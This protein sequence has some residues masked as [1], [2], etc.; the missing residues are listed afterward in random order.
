MIAWKI[1]MA[2]HGPGYQLMTDQLEAFGL[3]T[4]QGEKTE[5][6]GDYTTVDSGTDPMVGVT[7]PP[8]AK[9]LGG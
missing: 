7:L 3:Y 1:D 4:L 6:P 2:K 9:K 5:N 8:W